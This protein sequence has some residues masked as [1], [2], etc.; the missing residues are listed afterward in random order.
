MRNFRAL[1]LELRLLSLGIMLSLSAPSVIAQERL[2]AS[3]IESLLSGNTLSGR[4]ERGADFHVYHSANGQ[5]SGQARLSYY[6]V[7]SWDVTDNGE[8]CRQWTNWREGARDCFEVFRVGDNHY[9]IKAVNYHYD[10]SFRIQEGDP[11]NLR[12][13]M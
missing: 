1:G 2:S 10:S 5:T 6:D 9:R 13:R 12:N 4:T 3:E 8:Y 11:E 7:G